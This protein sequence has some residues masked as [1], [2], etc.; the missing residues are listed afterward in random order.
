MNMIFPER[1]HSRRYLT[2]KNAAI[3]GIALVAAF[4]LLSIWSALRPA[5]SGAS[6]SL[7][8]SRVLSSPSP[9]ARR[10][11][12]T[13]V[14]EGSI[15]DH[16]GAVPFLVDPGTTQAADA[17]LAASASAS[18]SLTAAAEQQSFEHRESKLGT[19]QRI[20]ISGGAEGV[21]VHAETMAPP[22]STQ[23]S[24][25]AAPVQPGQALQSQH[26]GQ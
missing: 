21:Q 4:M 20:T 9:S 24:E 17:S 1:R 22:A 16:P 3:T 5:H 14:Q 10:E 23:R 25:T 18:A 26:R 2:L 19:G 7:L 15:Y 13:I 12:V 6:G 8:Q 11:P